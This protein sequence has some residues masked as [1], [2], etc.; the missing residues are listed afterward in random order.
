MSPRIS[1]VV[2]AFQEGRRIGPTIAQ[3]SAY[4]NQHYPGSELIV[5]CDGCTDNTALVA[6]ENFGAPACEFKLIELPIN[7][8]KGAAV[9]AGVEAALG[10]YIFY[11]DADLSFAPE[12]LELFL[13]KLE[14]GA[15]VAIAQRNKQ[16]TYPGAGRRLLA[17]IS[18]FIVGNLV[19][20]GIRDTQAGYKGFRRAAAKPLFRQ[21]Q[22]KRFL[23]DLEILV[24]ARA[25]NLR[26]EKVYVDWQDRPGSTVRIGLDTARAARDLVLI[27]LRSLL[28]RYNF[29]PAEKVEVRQN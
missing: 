23:F 29:A 6:K 16:Q 17:R 15:D 1:M 19:L 5:V 22:V 20:P 26:I 18:R 21:L 27:C 14:D 11:T 10:D 3:L 12:V 7:R 2:P 13:P 8:G 24:M 28:G 4:L 9:Q 25:N